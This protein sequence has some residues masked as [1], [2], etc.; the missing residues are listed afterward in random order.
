MIFDDFQWVVISRIEWLKKNLIFIFRL[1]VWVLIFWG[2]KKL[3]CLFLLGKWTSV[4]RVNAANCK[5]MQVTAATSVD[6]RGLLWANFNRTVMY[7]SCYVCISFCHFYVEV[8][9]KKFQSWKNL[10]PYLYLTRRSFLEDNYYLVETSDVI[11]MT[12]SLS[13]SMI[14]AYCINDIL[15]KQNNLRFLE[16]LQFNS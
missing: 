5:Q 4:A 2:D 7:Y 14:M 12:S 8:H 9:G 15:L 1:V 11:F 3:N 13:W 10:F 6:L 16:N